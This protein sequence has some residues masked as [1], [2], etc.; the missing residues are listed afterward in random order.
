MALRD[1]PGRGDSLVQLYQRG[2]NLPLTGEEEHYIWDAALGAA[3]LNLQAWVKNSAEGK[4]IFDKKRRTAGGWVSV[5]YPLA[6]VQAERTGREW[7]MTTD[8]V[9]GA[10]GGF[11][12]D[13]TAHLLRPAT[14]VEDEQYLLD[15]VT[16]LALR[17]GWQ[18]GG[19]PL[20]EW[21]DRELGREPAAGRVPTES[22]AADAG[23][24]S[25]G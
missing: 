23:E 22:T 13:E 1:L 10:I 8:I 14:V 19:E 3:W 2:L 25:D 16:A 11:D 4:F 9:G 15:A 7:K 20:Y 17:C 5:I 21:L 12:L 24:V 6:M 18:K